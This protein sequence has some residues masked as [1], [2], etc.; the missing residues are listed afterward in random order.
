MIHEYRAWLADPN[1][2]VIWIAIVQTWARF[3]FPTIVLLA[4]LQGIPMDLYEAARVDGANAWQSLRRITFP[5]LLPSF[6]IALVVEFIAAFQVFDVVW[7]L[8]AGG[9]AGGAINPFTRT[10]MIYNYELVFRDL[11]VGLGAALS[12]LIL[13]MSLVVGFIFVRR[14]YNQ[15]IKDR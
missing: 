5:L 2:Q 9:S 7:T 4:G 14:L 3:S 10:L 12:Y 8:T 11:R 13:V 1:T 6:A 15:G